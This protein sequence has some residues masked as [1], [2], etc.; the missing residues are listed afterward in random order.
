MSDGKLPV[1]IVLGMG[2]NGLAVARAIGQAGVDLLVLEEEKNRHQ[3]HLKTRYG[4]KVFLESLFGSPVINFLGLLSQPAVLFPT[5]DQQV[6]WLS[7]NRQLI[8]IHCQLL[9]PAH[10]VV[11]KLLNK[12]L[13]FAFCQ[14]YGFPLPAYRTL[15]SGDDIVCRLDGLKFPLIIKTTT[16]VYKPGLDKAYIVSEL[17]ELLEIWARISCLHD[18]FLIQEFIPGGDREVYFCL[19][20]IG[21]RGEL[22]ASFTGRKIRQW[23]PGCGGTASCE[24]AVAPEL[25]D[26]TYAIF[27]RA[28]FHGIGSM[29]FKRDPRDNKFYIVEPTVC[30][31]DFQEQVAIANGVNIPAIAFRDAVDLPVQPVVVSGG[32][33]AWVHLLNDR[34]AADHYRQKGELSRW[35]W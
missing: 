28:G 13:F 21:L 8:P 10:D 3:P 7:E 33:R 12:K 31:T 17:R 22:L 2:T 18:D 24:P 9:L 16:K 26:Q 34:L 20:Y 27:R 6:E 11:K 4:R 15:K 29:E 19:Q 25:A 14:Q 32:R 1:A 30:R 23:R 5:T 35:Q